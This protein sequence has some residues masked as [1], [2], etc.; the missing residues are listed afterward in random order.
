MNW[1]LE[2]LQLVLALAGGF[3]FW[4]KQ[5]AEAKAKKA[6][7]ASPV[8]PAQPAT[9]AEADDADRA[10]KIREEILR[11]IAERRGGAQPAAKTKAPEEKKLKLPPL[12]APPLR[13]VDPFGGPGRPFARREATGA[14][15]PP[16]TTVRAET[17]AAVLA[18]QERLAQQLRD[19]ENQR[20]LAQ[21]RATA[22]S[23]AATVAEGVWARAA[24]N[25]RAEL[26][27]PRAVRHAIILR[28]V[29]GPPVSLR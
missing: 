16:V 12:M 1:I 22:T 20:V 26:R 4:L 23:E 7:P 8:R 2:H 14:M 6:M 17:E 19:L 15:E 27:E 13:P 11:K 5:R 18:R 9:M 28:E 3:A 10:R 29:L 21:R 24:A 25:V